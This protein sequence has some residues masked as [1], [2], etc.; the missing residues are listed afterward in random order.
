MISGLITITDTANAYDIQGACR[1][2]ISDGTGPANGLTVIGRGPEWHTV[3]PS[4]SNLVFS[5]PIIA[6]AVKPAGTY[7]VQAQCFQT[8]GG[9]QG[10]IG[11][12]L[13]NMV[14]WEGAQ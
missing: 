7:N 4:T 1:L 14:V 6:Y 12:V 3:T 11:A 13:D 9:P 5:I 2:R 10:S 8:F